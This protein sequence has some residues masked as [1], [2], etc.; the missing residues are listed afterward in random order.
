MKIKYVFE[1]IEEQGSKHM[2]VRETK[3]EIIE[4]INKLAKNLAQ[5]DKAYKKYIIRNKNNHNLIIKGINDLVGSFV[6]IIEI[7]KVK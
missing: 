3:D 1:F 4:R 2:V 7:R 5:E 6:N